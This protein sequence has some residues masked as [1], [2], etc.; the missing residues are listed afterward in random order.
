MHQQLLYHLLSGSCC[1]KDS[2]RTANGVNWSSED[3]KCYKSIKLQ[4]FQCTSWQSG[5]LL[6][7]AQIWWLSRS[8]GL[9]HEFTLYEEP[10]LHLTV[11]SSWWWLWLADRT[12]GL[13]WALGS[14][15]IYKVLLLSYKK[16]EEYWRN[17]SVFR[18]FQG[19]SSVHTKLYMQYSMTETFKSAWIPFET[20]HNTADIHLMTRNFRT[21]CIS[22]NL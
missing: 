4:N 19:L 15:R 5:Q 20:L 10:P 11:S 16:E 6:L 14:G 7:Q 21:H 12:C 22:V 8:K 13:T 3:H 1:E 17:C 2:K 18:K 9:V